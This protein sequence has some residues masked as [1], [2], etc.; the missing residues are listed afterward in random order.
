MVV[1]RDSLSGTS[2]VFSRVLPHGAN[3]RLFVFIYAEKQQS[4]AV[5]VEG[6]VSP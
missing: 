6:C 5:V 3:F 2:K 4:E 1:A